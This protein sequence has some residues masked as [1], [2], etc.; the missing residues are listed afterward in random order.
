[1]FKTFWRNESG[2]AAI[3]YVI[4]AG[5]IAIV[6]IAGARL[7]GTNLSANYYQKVTSNLT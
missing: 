4:V 3:E 1:M 6:I 5:L 2:T 7:V